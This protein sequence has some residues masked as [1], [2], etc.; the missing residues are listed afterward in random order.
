M[1][2]SLWMSGVLPFETRPPRAPGKTESLRAVGGVAGEEREPT[3]ADVDG[4]GGQV[5]AADLPF[6]GGSFFEPKRT[7]TCGASA[8]RRRSASSRLNC[9][10]WR[11]PVRRAKRIRGDVLGHGIVE[12]LPE[13]TDDLL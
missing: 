8:S 9:S 5:D 6:L 13:Q 4:V 3:A 2:I 7:T 12:H 10:P 11:R 1:T